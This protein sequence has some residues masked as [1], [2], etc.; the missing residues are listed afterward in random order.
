LS[1]AATCR[2][3][4]RCLRRQEG[5]SITRTAGSAWPPS[6][7]QPFYHAGGILVNHNHDRFIP[8]C[9]SAAPAPSTPACSVDSP[10]TLLKEESRGRLYALSL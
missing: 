6:G 3:S 5:K 1:G 2:T 10:P 7:A 9:R 4:F 8:P